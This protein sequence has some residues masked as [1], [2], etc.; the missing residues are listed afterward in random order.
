[1]TRPSTARGDSRRTSR[2]VALELAPYGIQV[3]AVAPGGITT[4]GT[5]SMNSN[6]PTGVD[7][8]TLMAAFLAK[9]P[10]RRIGDPDEIDKVVLFLLSDMA[11]YMTG[12]Q[13]V[14][15]GGALLT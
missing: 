4:P 8:E 6:A 3:N 11:S 2:N 12:S 9:I 1:M 14:V 10:M 7:T 15:D 5:Q 13:V